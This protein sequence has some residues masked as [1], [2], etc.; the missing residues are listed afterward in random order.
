MDRHFLKPKKN[1]A[2]DSKTAR[3]AVLW[4]YRKGAK[5]RGYSFELTR[6]QFN[7]LTKQD[8]WYCGQKPAQVKYSGSDKRHY[9]LYN[10]I[11][12]VDNAVGYTEANCI[13]CCGRC[14]RMKN[15]LSGEDFIGQIRKIVHNLGLD[16][17]NPR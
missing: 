3:S 12:R 9:C 10:G 4:N 17:Y 8:C 6:E 16:T 5:K 13:P 2:G 1:Y 14:N 11:D 15:V 7:T